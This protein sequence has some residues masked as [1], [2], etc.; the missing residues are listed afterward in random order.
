METKTKEQ[1]IGVLPYNEVDFIWVSN[2]WNGNL[3]GTCL[4]N[5]LLSEF[6]S[7]LNDCDEIT[8]VEIFYLTFIKRIRWKLR[9]WIFEQ[10]VGYHWSY[11][12]GRRY[13]TRNPKWFYS[14][15]CDVYYKFN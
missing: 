11:P 8:E 15:L 13:Y 1:V 7:V 12:L 5:G 6:R 10:C 9:Q 4:Y 2:Y 3:T 14:I